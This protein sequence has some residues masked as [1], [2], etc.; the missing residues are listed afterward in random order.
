MSKP[1]NE[2][3]QENTD[4]AIDAIGESPD[5]SG[6]E[7]EF[8]PLAAKRLKPRK[9]EEKRSYYIHYYKWHVIIGLVFLI[10]AGKFIYDWV[11]NSMPSA[12]SVAVLNSKESN[13]YQEY[14]DRELRAYDSSIKK[15]ERIVVEGNYT[16]S[17]DTYMEDFYNSSSSSALSDA[18]EL[19]YKKRADLFDVIISD[20][21]GI[22][23]CATMGL[24]TGPQVYL[25][26][27]IYELVEDHTYTYTNE[28]GESGI[29]AIDISG[30]DFAE[31]LKL[32][33]D[34]VYIAFPGTTAEN[35]TNA[36]RLVKMIFED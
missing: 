16:I 17:L 25:D 19:T 1:D 15:Y 26:S 31:G 21:A 3:K 12:L 4:T 10:I 5:D 20:E 30:T 18:E 8:D 9:Q 7:E 29:V 22:D 2:I 28:A 34:T 23:Y 33:Y 6:K 11:R 32:D 27:D 14:M 36:E 24:L 35:L 13:H